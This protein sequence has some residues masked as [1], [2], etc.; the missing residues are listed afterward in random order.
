MSF[1]AKGSSLTL[2]MVDNGTTIQA[3]IPKGI[4]YTALQWSRIDGNGQSTDIAAPA[5][6]ANP[7][8]K[9]SADRGFAIAVRATGVSIGSKKTVSVPY[10]VPGAPTIGTPVAASGQ[11]SVPY[12]PPADDGGS[13]IIDVELA[14]YL[15]ANDA[16]VPPNV[17]GTASPLVKT[18]LQN[19]TQYYHKVRARNAQGSGQWSAASSIVVP[20]AETVAPRFTAP[21]SLSG[22][23]QVSVPLTVVDGPL[24]DGTG[25][26]HSRDILRDGQIVASGTAPTYTPTLADLGHHFSVRH[27]A[28][29]TL[30]SDD[31]ASAPMV[32]TPLVGAPLA[33]ASLPYCYDYRPVV[34]SPA[35]FSPATAQGTGVTITYQILWNGVLQGSATST[36]PVYWPSAT[37]SLAMRTTISN[38]SGTLT[39]DTPAL[40]VI[41][42]PASSGIFRSVS[43]HNKINLYTMTLSTTVDRKIMCNDEHTVGSGAIKSFRLA[44]DCIRTVSNLP[45]PNGNAITL[46]DVYAVI[47]Y[48]GTRQGTPVRVTWNSGATG[49]T[50]ADG[51]V[52]NLSDIMTP[53]MFGLTQIPAGATINLQ[54]RWD[55]PKNTNMPS[56]EVTTGPTTPA[57]AYV[58]DPTTA[59]ITAGVGS[60]VNKGGYV[61]VQVIGST[62]IQQIGP[63]LRVIGEFVAG[64]P[65]VVF[66]LGDSTF[67]QGN[68]STG[69]AIFAGA[70]NICVGKPPL[71]AL[72]FQRSGASWP[73]YN[74]GTVP[75]NAQQNLVKYCNVVIDGAGINSITTGASPSDSSDLITQAS[76]A[77]ATM[78]LKAVAA[79][80]TIRQLRIIRNGYMIRLSTYTAQNALSSDQ[81]SV[82]RIAVGGDVVTNFEPYCQARV[83]DGTIDVFNPIRNLFNLNSDPTNPNCY[84]A[85]QSHFPDGL[86]PPYGVW[87]G[88]KT[89]QEVDTLA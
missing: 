80:G 35:M 32:C 77:W 47:F 62:T 69:N 18:G 25:V 86:H 12:S 88:Y 31:A 30:G 59:N 27:H 10:D 6:A 40:N 11:S 52:D 81:V 83:A 2:D 29:N 79:T 24:N 78:K 61:S 74:S 3:V 89:R 5:G 54:T 42:A 43:A 13:A 56:V 17:I 60:T 38:G 70:V 68:T 53:S 36:P 67:G 37:G 82:P 84:K 34:G 9:T 63:K 16:L 58:Y 73:I 45:Q 20:P 8:I 48:N 41:A 26:T 19:G 49:A 55:W 85:A 7:Y 51:S 65:K 75:G 21:P 66:G 28:V 57:Q 39:Y 64:D 15:K 87:A 14:T 71:A 23:P 1:P 76:Q 4:I 44:A 22:S 46:E 50:F 72:N 33:F